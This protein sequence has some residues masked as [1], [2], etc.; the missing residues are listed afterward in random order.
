MSGSKWED[1]ESLVLLLTLALLA[2][3][4]LRVGSAAERDNQMISVTGR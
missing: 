4:E 2:D 1:D 3:V